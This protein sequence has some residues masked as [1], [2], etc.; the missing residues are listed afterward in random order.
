MKSLEE[1][2]KDIENYYFSK[3][4]ETYEKQIATMEEQILTLETRESCTHS[5]VSDG[6][7]ANHDF[8]KCEKCGKTERD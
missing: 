2:I 3:A 5:F 1:R 4:I 7:N 6:W 8:Y